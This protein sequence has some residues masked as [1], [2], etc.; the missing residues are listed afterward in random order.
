MPA[1]CYNAIV[2]YFSAGFVVEVTASNYQVQLE[3]RNNLV[4]LPDKATPM[5]VAAD[6]WPFI[7]GKSTGTYTRYLHRMQSFK[8][9]TK[10]SFNGE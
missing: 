1:Y 6:V 9:L 3:D 10:I 8:L 4:D 5:F 7:E 2:T